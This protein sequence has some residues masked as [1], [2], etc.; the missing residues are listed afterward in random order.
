[1][2]FEQRLDKL[3]RQFLVIF[4]QL[5]EEWLQHFQVPGRVEA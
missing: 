2:L 1:L 3:D 4:T 5:R